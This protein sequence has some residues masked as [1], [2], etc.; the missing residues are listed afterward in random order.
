MRRSSIIRD[1]R[2]W[3]PS[4]VTIGMRQFRSDSSTLDVGS[5]PYEVKGDENLKVMPCGSQLGWSRKMYQFDWSDTV[6]QY[7]RARYPIATQETGTVLMTHLRLRVS[8]GG[9]KTYS[10]VACMLVC[11]SKMQ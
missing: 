4:G 11:P 3:V 1:A 10:P 5:V 2:R 8:M 9:G 7:R 6:T